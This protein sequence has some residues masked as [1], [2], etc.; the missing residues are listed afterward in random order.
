MREIRS[1][2][3]A[4]SSRSGRTS[5]QNPVE[6]G[7]FPAAVGFVF[8]FLASLSILGRA[9]ASERVASPSA[10]E[11]VAALTEQITSISTLY[12][13]YTVRYG[14]QP[15]PI[16]CRYA[17]SGP[18]WH[19]CELSLDP[20]TQAESE[21]TYSFDGDLVYAY[22]LKRPAAGEAVWSSVHL[23]DSREQENFVPDFLIGAKLSNISRSLVDVLAASK[24]SIAERSADDQPGTIRLLAEEV[25]P[26]RATAGSNKY[27][28]AVV[29]SP[30]HSLLP[31]RIHITQSPETAKFAGW[32]QTWTISEF[33]RVTDGRTNI[34]R[35][36]PVKGA[37][38]QGTTGAPTIELSIENLRIN[39]DLPISLFK[40]DIPDGA[41]LADTTSDGRGKLVL[42][43]G[44]RLMEQQSTES[45][46]RE[47]EIS[48]ASNSRY[49]LVAGNVMAAAVAVGLYI[50]W[51]TWFSTQSKK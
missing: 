23:Q 22:V 45:V 19:Y 48:P 10:G 13:E 35:W 15:S 1:C 17:R 9:D 3:L 40:P 37:L 14:D 41:V 29:L 42:Q 4:S 25:A 20:A 34:E 30:D 49:W 16:R 24:P 33:R 7:L 8:A 38:E 51:R 32:A 36:F 44:Q 6:R 39:A 2:L 31:E 11:A 26:N 43:G 18:K 12:A 46:G 47:K 5:G 21:N 28:I 50:I 27:N